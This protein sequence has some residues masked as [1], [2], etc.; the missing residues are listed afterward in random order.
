ME[1]DEPHA[2]VTSASRHDD[3]T[4]PSDVT[5]DLTRGDRLE[6]DVDVYERIGWTLLDD[7]VR[8]P[9]S[10]SDALAVA[11]DERDVLRTSRD[12][13][14]EVRAGFNAAV[15]AEALDPGSLRERYSTLAAFEAEI[16]EAELGGR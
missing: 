16:E 3:P 13:H 9:I 1:H 11:D 10:V 8:R 14:H 4:G 15:R 12:V 5:S 2:V 6:I 7:D